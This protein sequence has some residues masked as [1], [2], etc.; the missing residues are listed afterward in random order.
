MPQETIN[1]PS[2]FDIRFLNG[3]VWYS[4]RVRGHRASHSL[5]E[6]PYFQQD[7]LVSD[8]PPLPPDVTFLPW[9]T[10]SENLAFFWFTPRLGELFEKPISIMESDNE[11]IERTKLAQN[12]GIYR[13]QEIYYK[14]DSD[15]THYQMLILEEEPRSYQDFINGHF[16]EATIAAPTLLVRFQP[17][18]N[19]YM[20]FR[21]RDLGGISNPTKVF[22]YR[23]NSYGDGIEHEIE[24]H[25]FEQMVEQRLV[26]FDQVVGI[27]PSR[28]Q[29]T[30]NFS[31]SEEYSEVAEDLP[32]LLETTRGVHGLSLGSS[33]EELW[34]KTFVFEIISEETG[35]TVRVEATWKQIVE[36]Q[37]QRMSEQ[38]I[39]ESAQSI[40]DSMDTGECMTTIRGEQYIKNERRSNE[41]IS[42]STG[43]DIQRESSPMPTRANPTSNAA[44]IARARQRRDE[45]ERNNDRGDY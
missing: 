11:I 8:A 29:R 24:E 19:Y 32:R 38:T 6:S 9:E 35:K 30:V 33:E 21:A 14:S 10:L 22:R 23:I 3:S 41:S 42:R 36:S 26:Q 17:N 43:R 16:H 13:D 18:R 15:P 31:N 39:D 12:I 27:S 25:S 5:I 20:T 4:L 45:R 2:P 44:A 1:Q 40:L 28:E 37:M 34:N 7:L